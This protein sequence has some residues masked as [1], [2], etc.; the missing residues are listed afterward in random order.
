MQPDPNFGHKEIVTEIIRGVVD[1]VA[2]KPGLSPERQASAVQTVVCS[3][4]A[5]IPRD[6]V[7]T[8][9]AG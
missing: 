2:S 4:M 3:V 1:T 5:F 9:M 8:M 7:E 6:P